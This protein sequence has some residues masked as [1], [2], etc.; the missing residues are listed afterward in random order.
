MSESQ[1][2]SGN[3][4]NNDSSHS[5][6]EPHDAQEEVESDHKGARYQNRHGV[7]SRG[8][9]RALEKFAKGTFN[10][11]KPLLIYATRLPKKNPKVGGGSRDWVCNICGHHFVGSYT[12]VKQHILAIT[13]KGVNMCP[14]KNLNSAQR[15]QIWR[16]ERVA[17]GK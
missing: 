15:E 10:P 5:G 11:L 14:S 1:T 13:G 12:R 3:S 6:N 16:L 7:D 17:T 8:P 2:S 4:E 9:T